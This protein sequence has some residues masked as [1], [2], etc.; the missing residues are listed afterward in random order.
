MGNETMSVG[1]EHSRHFSQLYQKYNAPLR[2]DFLSQLSD[3][4][5]AT[6]CVWKTFGYFFS[7]MKD[8]PWDEDEELI[9]YR[10]R[11]IAGGVCTRKLTEKRACLANVPAH[12]EKENLLDKVRREVHRPAVERMEFKQ[13]LLGMFGSFRQPRLKQ[14]SAF[15]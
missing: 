2:S 3:A 11:M 6:E 7:Y 13:I 14:L 15:R 4:S 5:E 8:R 9:V 12:Q 10:L 1:V